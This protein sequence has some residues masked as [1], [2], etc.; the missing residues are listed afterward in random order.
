MRAASADFWVDGRLAG[1][2]ALT[3]PIRETAAPITLGG[4][5][6]D[7]RIWQNF[8]GA[9]DEVRL[10][11]RASDA[12]EMTDL[13]QPVSARHE[14]PQTPLPYELWAGEAIPDNLDEIPYPKGMKNS[15]IHCPEIQQYKFL[16]G[17]AIVEHKGVMY[18]I[19]AN[20][21]AN[22]NGPDETLRGKR[23]T[24]GGAIRGAI[25]VIGPR[26]E[27]EG[28]H[29]HGVL[30]VHKGAVWTICARFGIGQPGRRFRGLKS[31]AFV[32]D[33]STGQWKSKGI[34]MDNC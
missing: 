28:R 7:G 16:H 20:S 11:A 33:P 26:F 24:D 27:G 12:K 10:V 2:V 6:D 3:V 32:L 14:L 29:S 34:V 15:V 5:D 19:W 13:Y 30:F 31:E 21:P 4:V 8:T 1:T 17:A 22:K 25:E 18:A 23:S 9:L